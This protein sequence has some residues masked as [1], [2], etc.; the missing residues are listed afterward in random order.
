MLA[1]RDAAWKKCDDMDKHMSAYKGELDY[2]SFEHKKKGRLKPSDRDELL[3]E[4]EHGKELFYTCARD[5]LNKFCVKS[6]VCTKY[7]YTV[8]EVKGVLDEKF[9]NHKSIEIPVYL[10][11]RIYSSNDEY[12]NQYMPSPKYLARCNGQSKVKPDIVLKGISLGDYI[13]QPYEAISKSRMM[14]I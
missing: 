8:D 3:A 2:W 1:Q 14:R 4:L 12:V 10:H 5:V 9:Y 7:Y 13:G 6:D 11:E